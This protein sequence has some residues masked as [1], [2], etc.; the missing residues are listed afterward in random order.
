MRPNEHTDLII[1]TLFAQ[2]HS[3]ATKTGRCLRPASEKIEQVTCLL[4]IYVLICNVE[5]YHVRDEVST[6]V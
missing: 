2:I 4:L 1:D 3:D 5:V 6:V